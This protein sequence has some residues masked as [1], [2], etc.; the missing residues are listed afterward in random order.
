MGMKVILGA[1]PCGYDLKEAV[2]EALVKDGYEVFDATPEAAMF[3]DAAKLVAQA[4]HDG[5]YERGMIF[6]GTGM[7]VSIIA[8]KYRGVYAALCESYYQAR[9]ARAVN[10]ANVLCMGGMLIAGTLGADMARVFMET[11]HLSGYDEE[12][13]QILAGDYQALLAVEEELYGKTCC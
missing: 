4:V 1:D 2:K 10:N 3:Y 8:N 12:T 6:C 7:G 11:G 9:R 5:R 13:A